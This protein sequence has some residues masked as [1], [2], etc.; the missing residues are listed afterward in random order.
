MTEKNQTKI[1]YREARRQEISKNNERNI[2]GKEG[3]KRSW[4]YTETVT[5]KPPERVFFPSPSR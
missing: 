3:G 1:K 2:K 4:R 5:S